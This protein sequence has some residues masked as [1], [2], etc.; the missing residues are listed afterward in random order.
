MA[1]RAS[2]MRTG[3]LT[4]LA[5]CL[6]VAVC[7]CHAI[8]VYTPSLQAPVPPDLQPPRELSKVSL[9]TYRIEPPDVVRI[10]IVQLVPRP[11]YAIE[12]QDVLRIRV[13]GALQQEPIDGYFQ[14]Q[15]EGTVDLG[16]AY[17]V[18]RV[19]GMTAADAKREITWYLKRM[20]Q[21]PDVAVQLVRSA[22]A[23]QLTG[24]YPVQP[25][26]VINLRRCG[27]V[28]VAG[29]TVTEARLAV[30]Q[31][32]ALS[33]D[34]PRAS[35]E[36]V[37]YY[38]KDY[39]VI[40]AGALQGEVVRRFPITGNETVLDAVGQMGVL[41][42]VSSKTMWVARAAPDAL[43]AEQILPVDWNAIARGGSTETNYQ[44]LPGDRLFIVDDS[45]VA[46]NNYVGL[47]AS[48]IERLL[49][50]S[51]LGTTVA[52]DAETFGRSF[53]QSR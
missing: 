50:I 52:R 5:M 33:F 9:P 20:L 17:G 31:Q 36:V 13:W 44:L 45:L 22:G 49:G 25:D 29:K 18:V 8:D 43:G 7:G 3:M 11:P 48:P 39:H 19:A 21:Q 28:H 2:P 42:R 34:S 32:I 16:A 14:V 24:E 38:S 23:Q 35:V 4:V 53:N 12:P 40:V 37:G 51:S 47:L 30:E 1:S 41:S 10:E 46:L 15:P 26:G 6:S 27:M